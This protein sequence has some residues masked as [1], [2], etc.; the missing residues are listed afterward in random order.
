[1][2]LCAKRVRSILVITKHNFM[3][4]TIVATPLL[5][6]LRQIYPEAA[7]TLLTGAA[8]AQTLQEFPFV[9]SVEAYSPKGTQKGIAAS[10]RLICSL[11]K[12]I[13]GSPDLC[14][15]ADR[16]VRAASIAL[17]CRARVR[18][19]FDTE[20]RGFLLTHRVPYDTEKRESECCLDILRTVAPEACAAVTFDPMPLLCVTDAE[21]KRGA[22][23]LRE[24]EAIGPVLVGI[25]PGASYHA[26]QWA[27]AKFAEVA[28]ALAADG[29]GIV[30]LGRGEAELKA[31][32]LLREAAG[33]HVPI[34][35]LTGETSMRE[36]MGVLTHLSLFIGNDTGPSHIAASL[37][38]ATVSL[39]GPTSAEKWGE[40]GPRNI[41]VA[42]PDGK[43]R[44]LE[45][46]PVLAAARSLL[47]GASCTVAETDSDSPGLAV[48]A[49][50]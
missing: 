34:V 27:S 2:S 49:K 41:V 18:A 9:D 39:F 5:R 20:G 22:A 42:A 30:L 26:K 12:K 1:M 8:A 38:V 47:N 46:P 31:S 29:A 25:Q 17:L 45:V 10:W 3:G 44:K 28:T 21:R 50:R 15:V 6:A 36:T 13:G 37:S 14:L 48:G 23:I 33:K 24:R 40:K 19:G 16:S 43:L 11:R 7:I 35:D 4:D 32:R